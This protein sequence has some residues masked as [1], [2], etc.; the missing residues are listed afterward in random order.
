MAPIG[1]ILINS[2]GPKLLTNDIE[3]EMKE[4]MKKEKEGLEDPKGMV[5]KESIT[6][7]EIEI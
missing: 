3:V 4:R 1:A 6:K 5:Q 2:M 7:S